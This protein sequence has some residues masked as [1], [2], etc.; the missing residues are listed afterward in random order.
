MDDYPL[1]Q[2]LIKANSPEHSV[3][4]QKRFKENLKLTSV[5]D[6]TRLTEAS[7]KAKLK[8]F[9]HLDTGNLYDSARCF[10]AQIS[11]LYREQQTSSGKA[12][13]H[14]HPPG[15]RA[16]EKQGPTYTNLFKENWDDS[17][18]VDSIAAI[19]S[20]AAYLRALYLFVKQLETSESQTPNEKANRILLEKRRPDLDGL[21]IDQQS[22]FTA[23]PMLGII[24]AIL[25]Q[26]IQEALQRTADNGKSTY[27]VL[28]QRH[29][30]F[31]LPYEI[32]HHQCLLGLNGKKP[33]LGEL[34]YLIS[35]HLPTT[36][37]VSHQFGQILASPRAES[38]QLMSGLGPEQQK[39][40]K[41]GPENVTRSN[42]GFWK[43]TYGTDDSSSLSD[44][45]TFLQRTELNAEQLEALLSQGKHI[46]RQSGNGPKADSNAHPYGARYVNDLVPVNAF[47]IDNMTIITEE[48]KKYNNVNQ[49]KKIAHATDLR[50][51]RLQRMIRLRRWLDIPF[52][53]LDT[54]II[55]AFES[56][57]PSNK[58]MQINTHTIRTLGVYRY[59]SRRYS[60][61]AEEFAALLHQV[62]PCSAGND[63]PL[64]DRVF[65]QARLF[66]KPLVLDGRSFST[67]NSE[68]ASHTILQ[69]LSAS[70]GL[71]LT[72][73]S[74]LRAVKN[75]EKYTGPLKC[76]L[77]TLSSI[78]RQAR[79]ARM[80]G[81]SIADCA[82]LADLLGGE[83]VSGCLAKGKNGDITIRL[84]ARDE[85]NAFEFVARFWLPSRVDP[86]NPP[87]LLS[88][89]TLKTNT[90]W[91]AIPDV[92]N[93][94]I[95]QFLGSTKEVAI[96]T[97]SQIPTTGANKEVSLEHVPITLNDQA[98]E[99]LTH[100]ALSNALV[101]AVRYPKGSS[102]T[103]NSY[104]N[105]TVTVD[106]HQ[107]QDGFDMLDVLMQMD[108]ITNWINESVYTIPKLRRLLRPMS[109]E[110]HDFRDLQQYLSKLNR[111]A[112]AAAVTAQEITKLSL[113][114]KV[115]WRGVLSTTLLDNNGLVKNF[116]PAVEDDVSQ[117]LSTALDLLLK[118]LKLDEDA[119]KNTQFKQESKKKITYLLLAAHDRQLH[120]VEKFLQDTCLLPM[121]C[122]KGVVSWAKTSVQQ[123]L[124][125]ALHAEHLT[126]LPEAL[127]PVL[128]RAEAVVQLNLSNR[129]LR[130]FLCHPD[131]LETPGSQLELTLSS[132]YLLDRFNHC[133]SIHQLPEER[134]LSYLELANSNA[135]T[136]DVN[137]FLASL[138]SWTA[139][140]VTVL[141]MRLDHQQARTIKDV[142][143][144]MRCQ[145][146]CKATGLSSAALLKA[147]A[148]NSQSPTDDWK[149]VGEA[150]MAASH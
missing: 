107:E 97:I 149:K 125:T 87:L 89:S 13:H 48:V 122:A 106:E 143:W 132:L 47:N 59:L 119:S 112:T 26:N 118:E 145:A 38:Q 62:S 5:F 32:F 65:N 42:S 27:E 60:I 9:P 11:H 40:L 16:V 30:P 115:K 104:L 15:I 148:L 52:A 90:P 29:Y 6:I 41:E 99:A 64:L 130:L 12:Q 94:L 117:K 23:Q 39:L 63:A 83:R 76:D 31:A 111:D 101:T 21:L 45:H 110:D 150:V 135:S 124:T 61:N 72:E 28:A 93:E 92:I 84:K 54:L 105:V 80:F 128:R 96:I 4:L 66:E 146:T 24:N 140:E 86:A 70:L 73:D 116:A 137:S 43:T 36:Q 74:L 102:Q 20:P 50:L 8:A 131:W 17:C 3:E 58:A 10:A 55:G 2:A 121:N 136:T 113:P 114:G 56:Q 120:L 108:W 19:D 37:T 133:L 91:F 78:Y 79:I 44:M 18:K 81:I 34:N 123:I 77:I 98:L 22:T 53:E 88:G 46:P 68:P 127:H 14:W 134:L 129:A 82:T 95:S 139:A 75:T 57:V 144:L 33:S 7:F 35:T 1:L 67:N 25:D 109:R 126:R 85:G 103:L 71:P 51:A 100:Y 147:A 49:V 69:H 141:T 138:L 142:D